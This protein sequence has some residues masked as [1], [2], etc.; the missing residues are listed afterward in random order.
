M[1]D[2]KTFDVNVLY[3]W[4]NVWQPKSIS[5]SKLCIFYHDVRVLQWTCFFVNIYAKLHNHIFYPL[6]QYPNI[7]TCQC[8]SYL[9]ETLNKYNCY[10]TGWGRLIMYRNIIKVSVMYFLSSKLEWKIISAD[11]PHRWQISVTWRYIIGHTMKNQKYNIV[12]AVQ[13]FK[14]VP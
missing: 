1:G 7:I 2:C 11:I 5:M 9:I 14:G 8:A 13:I 3:I 12:R 10:A 4:S 6:F